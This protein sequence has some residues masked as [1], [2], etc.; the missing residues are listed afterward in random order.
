M[1][2]PA[3]HF[4]P[5]DVAYLADPYPTF[6]DLRAQRPGYVEALDMWVVS[7]HADVEA[8]FRDP[9]TYSAANAQDPLLPL[10]P[11]AVE[12]L[13]TGFRPIRTM[14][15]LDGPEHS[16]IRRHNQVG[17]SPRRLRAMEP[18]VRDTAVEL[19]EAIRTTGGPADLVEAVTFPMPASIIFALLGFPPEDTELLKGWCGD[20]MAFSWGHPTP[21]EQIGIAHDLVAYWGYCERHIE[22]RLDEPADDFT[23]DLL[24]IHLDDPDAISLHEVTHVVYGLSFAGHETTTNLLSNTVRRCLERPGTWD[25]LRTDPSS[26]PGAVDEG[27]RHDSSVIAW[28]RVTTAPTE[29]GGTSIPEGAKL[30]LLLG[31]ANRDEAVFDDPD[32]FDVDR[33]DAGRRHLSFGWGKHYCLG[34]TLAKVEV[35]VVL[36]ELAAR[37]P[38]LRLVEDQT[39]DFH[40]NVSFRGPRTLLVDW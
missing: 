23:S 4:D 10:D 17:F 40:P 34:A 12:I 19:I 9:E 18:V 2:C 5:F 33:A 13:A 30:L 27:L 38:G 24:R 15:N 7:R 20:R 22:R 39:L 6:A 37:L 11:A 8:V 29:L 3:D 16:R 25:R 36:E 28:R 35:A 32:R 26:V 1:P 31:A 14:S 21:E